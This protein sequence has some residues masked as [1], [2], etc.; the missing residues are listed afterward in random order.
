MVYAEYEAVSA[1]ESEGCQEICD[2]IINY[3]RAK[4]KFE[5]GRA[6]S[7]GNVLPVL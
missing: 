3:Y 7:I 6:H 5:R 4:T 2:R 1:L